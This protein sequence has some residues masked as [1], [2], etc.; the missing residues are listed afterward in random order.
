MSHRPL[1]AAASE[2]GTSTGARRDASNGRPPVL[3][4]GGGSLAALPAPDA[5]QLFGPS[6]EATGSE[7]EVAFET[8]WNTNFDSNFCAATDPSSAL[9]DYGTAWTEVLTR[10]KT[11]GL[12][13]VCLKCLFS[14]N[15]HAIGEPDRH[16][17]HRTCYGFLD[18]DQRTVVGSD[19]VLVMDVDEWVGIRTLTLL[20]IKGTSEETVA[21]QTATALLAAA[22][23]AVA[24]SESDNTLAPQTIT[25]FARAEIRKLRQK[26]GGASQP[27]GVTPARGRR[28]VQQQ[29]T[30]RH[31]TSPPPVPRASIG[32][33][34]DALAADDAHRPN[35]MG[36]A[37]GAHRHHEEHTVAARQS[38]VPTSTLAAM[39]SS[40]A[41]EGLSAKVRI[42]C[43]VNV[44]EQE[45]R[46]SA[47]QETNA[48]WQTFHDALKLAITLD[49]PAMRR[50]AIQRGI[51][52]TQRHN[53][54]SFDDADSLFDPKESALRFLSTR[55]QLYDTFFLKD[56]KSAGVIA[57]YHTDWM[58]M[59][60]PSNDS[61]KLAVVEMDS[62]IREV[63]LDIASL[64]A[65]VKRSRELRQQFTDVADPKPVK[66]PSD[67]SALRGTVQKSAK[68]D[69]YVYAGASRAA[70]KI[71][72]PNGDAPYIVLAARMGTAPAYANDKSWGEWLVSHFG[73]FRLRPDQHLSEQCKKVIMQGYL[74]Q[75]HFLV[76]S[77]PVVIDCTTLSGI[78]YMDATSAIENYARFATAAFGVEDKLTLDLNAFIPYMAVQ[79]QDV[80]KR[81][82][83]CEAWDDTVRVLNDTMSLGI[84]DVLRKLGPHATVVEQTRALQSYRLPR[85]FTDE[86]QY[87]Y[88]VAE[89]RYRASR[90]H[91]TLPVLAQLTPVTE[92]SGLAPV[93]AKIARVTTNTATGERKLTSA[94]NDDDGGEANRG[95]SKKRKVRFAGKGASSKDS[96]AMQQLQVQI[97]NVAA[98]N[99]RLGA[100]LWATQQSQ[101]QSQVQSQAQAQAEKN[102]AAE[103][104][105]RASMGV[106]IVG[107]NRVDT[108]AALGKRYQ[109][110]HTPTTSNLCVFHNTRSGCRFGTQCKD[111]HV[112]QPPKSE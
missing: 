96:E 90:L 27:T 35:L 44:S 69:E 22:K 43:T 61:L 80:N 54:L 9:G 40:V 21:R 99:S 50:K 57:N 70:L 94:A 14:V 82:V 6:D 38:T 86:F 85:S 87:Q 39:Q 110:V 72:T 36:G 3:F 75:L 46:L 101:V 62:I 7:D 88:D 97:K 81:P 26:T 84:P 15:H 66:G 41:K 49:D 24:A 83:F 100:Q 91:R 78:D 98:Q 102:Y 74:P 107:S 58:S 63:K 12:A 31:V 2:D 103:M 33:R 95:R 73:A 1:A 47:L 89:R 42:D 28:F 92:G 109:G 76:W 8:S 60:Y 111:Q 10:A 93:G 71:G 13:A 48:D 25:A 23:E 34:D 65:E 16:T 59:P 51:S 19:H 79:M 52:A 67:P 104:Q 105:R 64:E 55:M 56:G 32:Q 77:M 106:D 4:P 29:S 30:P 45:R 20:A 37:G 53:L 108:S 11:A 5:P 112:L 18:T 68:G 17:D